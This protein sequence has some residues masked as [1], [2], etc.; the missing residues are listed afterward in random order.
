MTSDISVGK[1]KLVK[2]NKVTWK[3]DVNSFID[4]CTI[5]LPRIAY[6]VTEKQSTE[7]INAINEKKIYDIKT[8]D[9]VSVSLGYNKK[10]DLRFVGFVKRV[11]MGIPVQLECE[12][13]GY[14]LYDIIFNKTYASVTV[15]Q[16]LTDLTAGTDIILSK[17][18]PDIPLKNVRFKNASGI[19]VLEWLKGEVK[20]SVYF[21]FNELFVGTMFGK[22]QDRVKVKIGWNTVKDDDFKQKN[23]D[24]KI[25]IVIR[26]KD[27]KGVVK[28]VKSEKTGKV[29]EK[30]VK[31][32]QPKQDK[33][34]NDKLVK[35]K[36]GIP[37]Q[38]MREIA[39]RL[40]TKEDYK[41]Y[42]G[43]II[44]F[45]KPYVRKGMVMELNGGIYHEKSGEY[46]IESVSG[47]FGE[48][49]GRQT[50]QLGFLMHK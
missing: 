37:A 29:T 5:Y 35:I 26:E 36:S 23:V 14:Q 3:S 47:E 2:P 44:L 6:L 41:G 10:N 8:G 7:D 20:L 50:A 22:V 38:F 18:I 21:N 1:Y 48:Q 39:N 17:E 33:Y 12:G 4:N 43:N 34:S 40:Q 32:K 30:I 16:L 11:N 31:P 19:K 9:K 15:K 49:G 46:F 25:N 42:E 45:L 28:K 27:Q 24:Q 13:Y